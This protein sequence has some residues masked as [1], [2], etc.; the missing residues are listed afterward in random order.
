MQLKNVL[1]HPALYQ[2][3]QQAGGFFGARVKA[4]AAY[5][6]LEGGERIIDIGCGPGFIVQH[7]PKSTDY[8]GYDPSAAYISYAARRFG[9]RGRFVEGFFDTAAVA[10]H[11]PADVVML[12]G[13][14][15]HLTD[16]EVEE[17]ARLA[18]DVLKPGGRL[19]TL[20]GCYVSGQSAIARRLLDNDRGRFVRTAPA[21]VALLARH[22][23]NVGVHLD[24]RL[25]RVPYTFITMVGRKS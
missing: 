16:A 14:L 9:M 12:N 1:A 22:F 6:P 8:I 25:S 10:Q 3:F 20:D 18:L 21:Y 23:A 19:F 24:H 5:L 4:I 7:L 2:S 17:V 15:H 13:V 11:M